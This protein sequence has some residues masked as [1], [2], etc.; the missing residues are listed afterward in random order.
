MGSFHHICTF[1]S[2][3]STPSSVI[4]QWLGNDAQ[5]EQIMRPKG[6]SSDILVRIPRR[7]LFVLFSPPTS[8]APRYL[9]VSNLP[10]T[11]HFNSS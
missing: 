3:L 2:L 5:F 8:C 1:V 6:L 9:R 11:L 7:I 10:N 4:E